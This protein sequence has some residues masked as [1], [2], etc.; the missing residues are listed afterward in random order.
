[1]AVV[2]SVV[3]TQHASLCMLFAL[4]MSAHSGFS[5]F[6]PAFVFGVCVSCLPL[7]RESPKCVCLVVWLVF[8]GFEV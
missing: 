3:D 2:N 6:F 7:F 4:I 8:L 1:M 5:F